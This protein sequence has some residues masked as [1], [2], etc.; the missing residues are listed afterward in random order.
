[1]PAGVPPVTDRPLTDPGAGYEAYLPAQTILAHISAAVVVTDR[2]GN[3]L[4]ANPFA[5]ALF[6]FPDSGKLLGRP[7]LSLAFSG[8]DAGKA[9]ELARQVLRGR[10]GDGTFAVL[11][12]DGSRV[13]VRAQAMPLRHPSGSVDGIVILAREASRRSSR[14]ERDRVSL[15][16]RIGEQLAG[17]LEFGTTLRHVAETLVPQFAD[18]CIIDLFRGSK[19]IRQ[20]QTNAG[21]WIPPAGSWARIGDPISYPEGHF[22]QQAMSRLE[23][24]L[25]ENLDEVQTPRAPSRTSLE[26]A[27]DVG[28]RSVVAAPLI[29]RGELLGVMSLALSG[30]DP[31]ARA[32]LRRGRPRLPQRGGQPGG[33]GHRQRAAVRGGA[34]HRPGLPDQ[35]AA[36]AAAPGWTGWRWPAGTCPP[37]RW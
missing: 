19:L 33:G 29:A 4:Y 37:S 10:G 22:C 36:P 12:V 17:S 3:L 15:L 13:F 7:V 2:Q 16:E 27:E 11:R 21:G 1:V 35:P 14:R 5:V 18:H 20:V 23:S 6:G 34:A 32:V 26:A 8:G 31:A 30:S 28:L 9:A 25:L 24:V